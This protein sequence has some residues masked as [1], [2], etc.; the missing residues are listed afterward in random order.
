MKKKILSILLASA[1]LVFHAQ[2]LLNNGAHIVYNGAAYIYMSGTANYTSQNGGIIDNIAAGGTMYLPGN[3]VNNSANLGFSNDG[4]G[5]AFYVGNQSI[6]GTNST[7]FYNMYLIG[8]GNK[9]LNINTYVG[10]QNLF[11]GALTIG[12]FSHPLVLNGYRLEVTNPNPSAIFVTTGYIVSETNA[13]LNPSVV[14]WNVGTNTGSYVVPFGTA[15]GTQIPLTVNITSGMSS[16]AGYFE[17]ATRPTGTSANTP[18]ASGVTHMYDP[19]LMQDGSDEA[20]IDRWWELTWSHAATATMTYS[21]L[22]SENTLSVPYNTGNLGAQYWGSGAWLPNNSNIGSAAAVGVGVGTVTAPGIAFAAATYTPMV[23]SSLLAPLPVEFVDVEAGCNGNHVLVKWSTA[24]ESNNDHFIIQRSEDGVYY[25][26]I[27]LQDSYAPG[28]NSTSMLNYAFADLHPLN[29]TAYYRIRQVDFNGM[30][31]HSS[32]VPVKPCAG[33]SDYVDVIGAGNNVDVIVN[34]ELAGD[35]EALVY[36]ARGRLIASQQL[37]AAQGYNR[38]R[39]D[40]G[41]PETGVYMV[42]VYG[43]QRTCSRKVYLNK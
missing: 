24:S 1:P 10:G 21:Y 11:N 8:V 34:A 3:W 13:A 40:L 37:N 7:N 27:G 26:D 32:I 23:L 12:A 6:G 39:L 33:I 16:A 31:E 28:G 14:R 29:A 41:L 35:Y 4:A 15:A 43:N 38:F 17:S 36:D 19:T 22:G 9:T 25:E 18:W 2:G 20:V 5:V 42:N 30:S